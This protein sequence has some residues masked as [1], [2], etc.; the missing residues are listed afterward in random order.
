MFW[1]LCVTFLF[2]QCGTMVEMDIDKMKLNPLSQE[3]IIQ[4][5]KI[6]GFYQLATG[7]GVPAMDVPTVKSL[8]QGT[9]LM[10]PIL[11]GTPVHDSGYIKK[12][13]KELKKKFGGVFAQNICEYIQCYES[14]VS[15]ETKE[16]YKAGGMSINWDRP[17]KAFYTL[18]MQLDSCIVQAVG[19]LGKFHCISFA[20]FINK[21]AVI[22]NTGNPKYPA[23][24]MLPAHLKAY[25]PK[26]TLAEFQNQAE[27]HQQ[28]VYN[29]YFDKGQ[30][31]IRGGLR[32][33]IGTG[34]GQEISDE[35]YFYGIRVNLKM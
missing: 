19:E 17:E 34:S 27:S 12:V 24:D 21:E 23:P 3:Q 35:H 20:Y 4:N 29:V 10:V 33:Q 25:L 14:F 32:Q 11:N 7:F 15:D 22:D 2:F 18:H 30:I 13:N 28:N 8:F 1:K 6:I 31:D 9:D 26:I 16:Y 5:E